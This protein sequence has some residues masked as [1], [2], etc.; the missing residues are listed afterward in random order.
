MD[1]A[2]G[3]IEVKGWTALMVAA[4]A[5]LKSADVCIIGTDRTKGGGQTLLKLGG[6]VAAVRVAV[7]AGGAAAAGVSTVVARHVIARVAE[8][9]V[10]CGG[11]TTKTGGVNRDGRGTGAGRDKGTGG[12]N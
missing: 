5:A 4:D 11:D 2:L 12:S 7:E 9:Q 1:R 8:P 3:L 10:W 6:E